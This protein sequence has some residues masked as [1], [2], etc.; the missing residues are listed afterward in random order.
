M[1]CSL[2]FS[3]GMIAGTAK[4]SFISDR[5]TLGGVNSHTVTAATARA[6][7]ILGHGRSLSRRLH[8]SAIRVP[9]ADIV[10]TNIQTNRSVDKVPAL[11]AVRRIRQPFPYPLD[12]VLS[13][14]W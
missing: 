6:F 7:H 3:A 5:D 9:N 13:A 12:S 4:L 1:T 11:S 14:R 8:H 10:I 2:A